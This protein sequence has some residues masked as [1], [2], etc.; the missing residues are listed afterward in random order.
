[1][2]LKEI[3]STP[4]YDLSKLSGKELK[5]AYSRVRSSLKSRLGTFERHGNIKGVPKKL[6]KGLP[7]ISSGISEREMR[8][9]IAR[10]AAWMRGRRS[11]N[12][13]YEK[14]I[15]E[16]SEKINEIVGEDIIKSKS[17]FDKYGKFMGAM[18]KRAGELW[19]HD[20]S[21]VRE[22]YFQAERWA[23]NPYAFI[24][25]Y[26]YWKTHLSELVNYEGDTSGFRS[27]KDIQKALHLETIEEYYHGKTSGRSYGYRKKAKK[28]K[29]RKGR[30]GR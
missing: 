2:K 4:Y 11:T 14:S 26:D 16:R 1:M 25:N 18:Q 10:S 30:K 7:T 12:A 15:A 19:Q 13:G 3:I 29:G 24:R 21:T 9:Q 28:S 23:R 20:S 8:D 27:T 5:G 22:M 17:D 6:R